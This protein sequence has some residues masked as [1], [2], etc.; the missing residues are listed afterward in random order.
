MR[1]SEVSQEKAFNAAHRSSFAGIDFPTNFCGQLDEAAQERIRRR[2]SYFEAG[3]KA[4]ERNAEW[5][6]EYRVDGPDDEGVAA[7][8]KGW[9][10]AQSCK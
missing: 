9:L 1:L 6:G 2:N 8:A 4:H 5:G 3:R 10:R 7:Y